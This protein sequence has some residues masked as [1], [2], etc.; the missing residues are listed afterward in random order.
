MLVAVVEV[1]VVVV[2]VE[3]LVLVAE[4]LVEH[5]LLVH[6]QELLAL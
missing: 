3:Q 5:H 6:L 4:V 1:L 2:Q